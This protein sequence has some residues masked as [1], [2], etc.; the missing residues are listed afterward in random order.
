MSTDPHAGDLKIDYV[1]FSSP[2]IGKTKAFFQ[3]AFG[4]DFVDYGPDYQAF[5]N[6][7]ID[8]G[9]DGHSESRIEPLVILKTDDINAALER[10]ENAGGVVTVPIFDFPGGRRFQFREPGGNEMAVWALPE[11]EQDA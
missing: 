9:V 6:A 2:E 10:V 4:W 11:P 7:G 8:G 3:A 5:A 1:E